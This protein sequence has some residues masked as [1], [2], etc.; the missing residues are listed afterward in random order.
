MQF[1]YVSLG[2]FKKYFFCIYIPAKYQ[3][4]PRSSSL[5]CERNSTGICFKSFSVDSFYEFHT[6]LLSLDFFLEDL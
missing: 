5:N 2:Q 4:D 6:H 3:N 1:T